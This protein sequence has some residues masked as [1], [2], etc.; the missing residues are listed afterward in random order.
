VARIRRNHETDDR[1]TPTFDAATDGFE[2][3]VNGSFDLLVNRLVCE[4]DRDWQGTGPGF[5]NLIVKPQRGA[6][7]SSD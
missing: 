5:T 2:E 6:W 7:G 4:V 3:I 1:I